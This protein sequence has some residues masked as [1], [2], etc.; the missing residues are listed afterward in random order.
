M[1]VMIDMLVIS[2]P[3]LFNTL[4]YCNHWILHNQHKFAVPW[5]W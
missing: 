5:S 1:L 2:Q 4:I 3:N